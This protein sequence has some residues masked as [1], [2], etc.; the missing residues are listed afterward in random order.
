MMNRISALWQRLI[1]WATNVL[2][3]TV[4]RTI[5]YHRINGNDADYAKSWKIWAV[6]LIDV[7]LHR[8][9]DKR[10]GVTTSIKA[11]TMNVFVGRRMQVDARQVEK[12]GM[13]R[14]MTIR[15]ITGKESKR[16]D[17]M[18]PIAQD[19]DVNDNGKTGLQWESKIRQILLY[20]RSEDASL[21]QWSFRLRSG[22]GKIEW[23][24][25]VQ[26]SNTFQVACE[27]LS[28]RVVYRTTVKDAP[29]NLCQDGPQAQLITT[30]HSRMKILL[31]HVD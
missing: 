8:R 5:I 13:T 3:I 17:D 31:C 22:I 25:C 29:G 1:W 24:L 6:M 30:T 4:K 9:K 27:L 12:A 16:D 10:R 23:T 21:Q 26:L 7:I 20:S 28:G 14:T 18:R 11:M 15:K 2:T 19:E